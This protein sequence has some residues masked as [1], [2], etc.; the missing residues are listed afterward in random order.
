M[1]PRLD[2]RDPLDSVGI[3]LDQIDQQ[4]RLRI[5]LGASLFPVF[6][7]ADVGSQIDGEEGTRDLQ[8]FAYADQFLRR[9]SWCRFIFHGMSSECS[10]SLTCLSE[11]FHAFAHF[12]EPIT[13]SAAPMRFRFDGSLRRAAAVFS[14]GTPKD[15]GHRWRP[16]LTWASNA[17]QSTTCLSR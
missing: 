6:Q 9:G 17:G 4:R 13:R 8:V 15:S 12:S 14:N 7:G 11:S 1:P 3:A 2:C 16:K 5:R 10:L